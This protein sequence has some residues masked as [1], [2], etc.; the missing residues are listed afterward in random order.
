MEL[1]A[2]A[3]DSPGWQVDPFGQFRVAVHD[4]AVGVDNVRWA[5]AGVEQLQ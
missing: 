4:A 3:S 1:D 5:R 2:A